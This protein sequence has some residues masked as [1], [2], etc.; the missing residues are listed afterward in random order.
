MI[1]VWLH[2]ILGEPHVFVGQLLG[3]GLACGRF[4]GVI[5]SVITGTTLGKLSGVTGASRISSVISGLTT[6]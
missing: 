2:E 3:C 4:R 6:G 5:V 1:T